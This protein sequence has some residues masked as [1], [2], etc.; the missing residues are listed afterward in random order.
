MVG[1]GSLLIVGGGLLAG[2][3]AASAIGHLVSDFLVEVTPSDPLTYL[4]LSFLLAFVA[5]LAGYIPARRA[6]KVDPMVALRYE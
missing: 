4:S 1:R 5:L 6:V 2:L 3:L